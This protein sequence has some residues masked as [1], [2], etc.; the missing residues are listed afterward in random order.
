MPTEHCQNLLSSKQAGFGPFSICAT[1][2]VGR[3]SITQYLFLPI[4]PQLYHLS[5]YHDCPVVSDTT[6]LI[7]RFCHH[8]CF[9][10]VGRA[11]AALSKLHAMLKG[12]ILHLCY[13]E[14]LDHSRH[15]F[16][17][18]VEIMTRLYNL[19][20]HSVKSEATMQLRHHYS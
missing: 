2:A 8:F 6:P 1:F 4:E 9:E 16:F 12:G 5:H 14:R 10:V 13:W 17:S 19:S 7:S 20:H 11:F 18:E 15:Q 3:D